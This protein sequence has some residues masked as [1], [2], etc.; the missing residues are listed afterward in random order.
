M[1]DT[2]KKLF[3]ILPPG[4]KWKLT[5]L[6]GLMMIGAL[7]EVAGIG[8]LPVFVSAVSDPSY[9]LD[10]DILGPIAAAVGITTSRDL[11]I[12]GG[13]A[14]VAIFLVKT[15]YLVWFKYI[16][17]KF[18][19]N[20]YSYISTRLYES[21]LS[22]PYTFHL[23]RN[24]AELIRNVTT[25]TNLITN[26]IMMPVLKIS[27][28]V[29]MVAGVFS[30]LFYVEPAVTLVSF[31]VIG[32]GGG[33]ILKLIKKRMTYFGK[34]AAQERRRMIQG[35]NEGIGG[36][37]DITV[38]NRQPLFINRMREYL[39]NLVNAQIFKSVASYASRPVIEF[40]AVGG[41]IFIA[42]F[43][44][45]Q[46][47]EMSS[48]IP[49][50]ALFGAA[51]VRLIPSSSHIVMDLTNLRYYIES[52]QAVHED[53]EAMKEE[54]KRA[55]TENLNLEKLPFEKEIRLSNIDYRY[56]DADTLALKNVSLTIQKGRAVGFV[57]ESGAGKSTIVDLVLGLLEP[58]S[59]EVRIDGVDMLTRKREWQN[60]VGYIP[61]FIYLSDDTIRSNI[62]FGVSKE[63]ISDEKIEAA[64]EA[65]QLGKVLAD[66]PDGLETKIG[67]DGVRLSGGQRQRIGIAR[68][69]YNNPAVLIMDEATSALDNATEKQVMQAIE[70]LKGERTII[71]IAHR[72]TTVENCDMLYLMKEGEIV[73]KGNYAELLNKNMEFKRMSF[74]DE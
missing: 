7:I 15:V 72:L 41:M 33:L 44:V 38:M 50:L 52:L 29:V 12:Y 55:R 39:E 13:L 70:A 62:A 34:I 48:I 2:L 27:M 9:I 49:I 66:L 24:S 30:F 43:M 73:E 17:S 20:R 14:L 26:N 23:G 19:M 63:E 45:W 32:G 42:F 1:T 65:A 59:G 28:D 51:A 8:M 35:V 61:Q 54:A 25:E 57:G 53:L 18:V 68:A 22:A 11:L 36:I 3:E 67:E 47:R 5:M 21:Y 40:L 4:D 64:V 74:T 71:M 60:N 6:F 46:G 16:K 58:T 69:L 31:A 56:P 10:N 37:K